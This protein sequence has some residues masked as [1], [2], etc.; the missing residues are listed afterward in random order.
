[1]GIHFIG[2]RAQQMFCDSS[3]KNGFGVNLEFFSNNMLRNSRVNALDLRFGLGFDIMGAGSRSEPVILNTQNSDPGKERFSN[4]HLG[5]TG[6]VRLMFL[7]NLRVNPY[8]DGHVGLRGFFTEQTLTMDNPTPEYE[9]STNKN[10]LRTGTQRW[11]G[12]VGLMYQI[13]RTLSL[14]T[15]V[16]YSYGTTGNWINLDRI[17]YENGVAAY[18]NS[19]TE[20]DLLIYHVGL[21]VRFGQKERE[22]HTPTISP[23]TT[24]VPTDTDTT[25]TTKPTITPKRKSTTVTPSTGDSPSTTPKKPLE[26]KPVPPPAPAPKPRH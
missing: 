11:G 20:T 15:R 4:S 7:P 10:I 3:Y 24:T 5:L 1:M 14:D 21:V 9:A 22:T 2:S 23:N 6:S 26:V 13:N 12:S 19:R 17:A 16:T 18:Q 25:P 8:I